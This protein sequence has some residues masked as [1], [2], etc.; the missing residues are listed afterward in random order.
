M[1]RDKKFERGFLLGL[2]LALGFS[3]G[4]TVVW[5]DPPPWAPAHGYRGKQPQQ[6]QRG[7]TYTYYPSSQVYYNPGAQK[8]Y[9]MNN[10]SWINGGAVPSSINLGKGVSINLDGPDPYVY[11]PTVLKQYPTN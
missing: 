6:Q 4:P 8:Y 7:Y 11:H 2:F 3:L 9:Y 1:K 5:A 10:G